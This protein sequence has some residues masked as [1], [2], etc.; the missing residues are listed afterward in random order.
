MTKTIK[1]VKF[2]KAMNNGFEP[3]VTVDDY[4]AFIDGER[5]GFIRVTTFHTE[6]MEGRISTKEVKEEKQLDNEEVKTAIY[7]SIGR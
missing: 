5:V 2:H 7:Q 1:V 4:K 3:I 6:D